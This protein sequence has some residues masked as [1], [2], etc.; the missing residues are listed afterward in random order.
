M[1]SGGGQLEQGNRRKQGAGDQGVA[2][3]VG[4]VTGWQQ[5]RECKAGERLEGGQEARRA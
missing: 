1:V 5:E 3:A 2:E 4:G